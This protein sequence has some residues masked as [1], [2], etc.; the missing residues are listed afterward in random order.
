MRTEP[1]QNG[2]RAEGEQEYVLRLG[3]MALRNG[4]LIHGPTSWAAAARDDAGGIQVAS[5]PK[6]ALAPDLAVR[7][8]LLR[9]PLRLAEAF[10]L[11][12]TVRMN[13]RAARLPFEDVRVIAAM[14][15]ASSASRMLRR[16]RSSAAGE[17]V[18]AALGLAPAMVALSDRNLAAYHGVEHK[19]IGAYEAGSDDPAT[20]TKEHER[21]GSNLVA[22]M[23]ILSAGGQ[24]LLERALREPGP[25][26]RAAIGVASASLAAEMFAWSERNPE[27]TAARA[28]HR[29]GHEIQRLIATKEPTSEQLE[30]G[31]AA[32]REILRLEQEADGERESEPPPAT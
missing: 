3:G 16:R 5:G 32:L 8:P 9:G 11:I 1:S 22:P 10:L 23:L 4:L 24:L 21:C 19:A 18:Q 2:D 7:V 20:A 29:P 13:L 28:F 25:I 26:A 31:I 27:T 6:P 17:L 15:I 30:V 12:P 14:L